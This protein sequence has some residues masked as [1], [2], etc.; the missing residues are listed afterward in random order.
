[1]TW[2]LPN[3]LISRFALDTA[4]LTWGSDESCRACEQLL[5]RRSKNLPAASWRRAW[6]AGTLTLPRYGRML[7]P[8]L[9]TSFAE[10][11]TSSLVATLA[12]HSAQQDCEGEQTTQG[13]CGQP[14]Q[15]EFPFSSQCCASSKTSRDTSALACEMSSETWA[16]EVTRRRGAYSA[17]LKSARHINASGS[18][19]WPTS[20][21]RDHKGGYNGG[22]I[23]NGRVSKDTLDVAVQAEESGLAAQANPSMDGNRQGLSLDWRTP[24]ANEAGAKVETLFTKHGQP[25]KPGERAYRKTPSGKMVLQ[26]QTINQQVKMVQAWATPRAGKVTDENPETWAIRNDRKEVATMPLTAQVKTWP[27]PAA[28]T[29]N[30]GPH[31]LGG[32]SGSN[33]TL[34]TLGHKEM[35]TGKLNPRWVET[36][37]GLPVGWVMPSCACPVTIAPMNCVPSE[38]ELFQQPPQSPS[39]R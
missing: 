6:K 8:S 13:T 10:R 26:S 21:T 2:I 18:S 15:T 31:G 23:R 22:R 28:S 4:A 11:W 3:S 12:S 16:A 20:S 37:M 7:E 24:Q 5:M 27:T 33:Q 39:Q 14:L 34:A 32:G 35:G 38:M 1:M 9:G 36:L 25:A 19:S 30:G 29:G 17:R